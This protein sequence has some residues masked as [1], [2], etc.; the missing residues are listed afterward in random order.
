ML[1]PVGILARS[2]TSK[3]STFTPEELLRQKRSTA[4]TEEN[5]NFKASA[6]PKAIF[7]KPVGIPPKKRVRLS[8]PET[9]PISRPVVKPKDYKANEQFDRTF[10][11][12][13]VPHYKP[14]QLNLDHRH[15][16]TH[17][18]DLP[19]KTFH[20]KKHGELLAKAAGESEHDRQAREFHA[21]PV[22]NFAQIKVR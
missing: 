4:G 1:K 2:L 17:S 11:A 10:K 21:R 5:T 3:K 13:P 7:E 9:P 18:P 6:V 22:P 20:L 15:T 19:G 12:P 14:F 8:I 16:E